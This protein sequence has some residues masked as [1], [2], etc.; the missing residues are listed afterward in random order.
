[1]AQIMPPEDNEY[2][3]HVEKGTPPES[4]NLREIILVTA[5]AGLVILMATDLFQ[6]IPLL[7]TSILILGGYYAVIHSLQH[8]RQEE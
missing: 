5:I 2:P 6:G 7:I 4:S 8:H 1:M 3:F